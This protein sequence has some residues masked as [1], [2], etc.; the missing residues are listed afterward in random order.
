MIA[1]IESSRSLIVI[2]TPQREATRSAPG[3]PPAWFL[4]QVM[5]QN[6]GIRQNWGKPK[7]PAPSLPYA[8]RGLVEM[9]GRIDKAA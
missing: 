2:G 7:R 4:A 5:N 3:V 6:A 1:P 9:P 8:T